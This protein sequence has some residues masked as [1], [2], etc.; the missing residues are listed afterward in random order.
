MNYYSTYPN[1]NFMPN[2]QQPYMMPQQQS[3][4]TQPVSNNGITWVQG[5]IG[6]KAYPVSAGNSM[7]LMDSDGQ[8]FYIKSADVSGMPTLRKYAYNEVVEEVPK[9]EQH[10]HAAVDYDTAK[11]ASREE[12]KALQ[13]EI[14]KLKEE[15][16]T[17]QNMKASQ[18]N[19]GRN[20]GK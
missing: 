11:L 16:E 7:L 10:S 18:N 2:Y 5:E 9:L 1:N 4:Q 8:Y 15:L 17:M 12:V 20:N 19:G 14:H 6:A 3:F 13:D